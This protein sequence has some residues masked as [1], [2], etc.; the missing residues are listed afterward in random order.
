MDQRQPKPTLCK[1]ERQELVKRLDELKARPRPGLLAR[2]LRERGGM[3]VEEMAELVGV[4]AK[5][6]AGFERTGW[7]IE[8]IA[9]DALLEDHLDDETF[10]Q[11]VDDSVQ[12]LGA[13]EDEKSVLRRNLAVELREALGDF[14]PQEW[15]E[16]AQNRPAH[17]VQ[18]P[19]E[20]QDATTPKIRQRPKK[21]PLSPLAFI[22]NEASPLAKFK[23]VGRRPVVELKLQVV[24]TIDG[25]EAKTTNLPVVSKS[26]DT[27]S[28]IGLTLDQGKQLLKAVQQQVV[29]RQIEAY[30]GEHAHCQHCGRR[31]GLKGHHHLTYRTLFGN[32]TLPSPRFRSCPCRQ[33]ATRPSWSPLRKLLPSRTAPELLMMEATWSSLVS[34]DLATKILKAFLPVDEKL[35]VSTLWRHTLK[36]AQRLEAELNLQPM[37]TGEPQHESENTD[38]EAAFTVGIDGG[39][40]RQWRRRKANFEVLVGK[41]VPDEGKAKCF[42]AVQQHDAEPRARVLQVLRSQG[43]QAGQRVRFLSDGER[44]VRDAQLRMG[45]DS[46]HVLD[47][48]HIAKRFTV[49]K[50]FIKGVVRI[51]KDEGT[52]A[53]GSSAYELQKKTDS[54]KWKLWHGKIGDAVERIDDMQWLASGF[55]EDYA[56]YTKLDA[57]I[58]ELSG[59]IERNRDM[60]GNYGEDHRS[61]RLIS[62]AFIESM[63]NSVLAKRFVKKQQM[64]WTPR[65]AHLLLQVRTALANQ[66]LH[67]AFKRWYPDFPPTAA[68]Q[69]LAIVD[70]DAEPEPS[71]A[72]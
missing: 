22:Q 13:N 38:R 52:Y 71:A 18:D 32:L 11:I 3:S 23:R 29:E 28:A 16:E 55:E 15:W 30:V 53:V 25:E 66:D 6:I 54:A 34:Y 48:F 50:Q 1:K 40:L 43:F 31:H 59:Y 65:G 67:K 36:T 9:Y 70:E 24:T 17:P 49:L 72:A 37:E 68:D 46:E 63:V 10:D 19:W 56:R 57:A 69:A 27:M 44:S 62:T 4:E 64:Q 47:W 21:P 20:N 45:P 35:S 8:S 41:S 58:E 2:E 39:Y 42:G 12:V 60:I 5:A 14:I 61:G 51:E 33:W 26:C 7:G